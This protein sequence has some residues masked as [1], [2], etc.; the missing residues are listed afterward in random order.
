MNDV[1]ADEIN[2]P[3]PAQNSTQDC[4]SCDI[5]SKWHHIIKPTKIVG[6]VMPITLT[7]VQDRALHYFISANKSLDIFVQ[8]YTGV[9]ST[10]YKDHS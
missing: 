1:S 9:D 3:Y 5:H 4:T 2:T 7:S 8:L 6:P 10:L